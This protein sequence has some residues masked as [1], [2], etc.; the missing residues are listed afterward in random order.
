MFDCLESSVII[1]ALLLFSILLYLNYQKLKQKSTE[2]DNF[3]ALRKT[4][5]DADNRLIYLKDE[6][7]RYIFV[8]RAMEQFLQRSSSGIIGRDDF[9]L[10]DKEFAALRSKT[11]LEALEKRPD[12]GRGKME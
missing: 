12:R 9:A 7:L 2:I 10:I 11:D 3:N 4:F 8:N 5:L 1:I 6:K